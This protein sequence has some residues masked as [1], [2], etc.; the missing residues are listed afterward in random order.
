MG[1]QLFVFGRNVK[2]FSEGAYSVLQDYHWPGN[3]RELENI[4]ERTVALGQGEYVTMKEMPEE[5]L[6]V[7]DEEIIER[8]LKKR[9]LREARDQLERQFGRR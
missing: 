3:V 2:K 4:I 5:V 7:N 1:W 9:F 8:R 6:K